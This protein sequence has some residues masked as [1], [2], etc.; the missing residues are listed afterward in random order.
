VAKGS[1]DVVVGDAYSG[2]SV[3]WHLTTL[4]YNRQIEAVLTGDGLYIM[5]V[6]D[7]GEL[8]FLRAETATLIEV[9]DEVAL[10]APPEYLTGESGG[11]FILVSSRDPVDLAAVESRIRGRG[12]T[13]IGISGERLD[14]FVSGA[15]VLTDDYAPVDQMLGR[16]GL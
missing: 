9:Y 11:N 16:A 3:P 12:G 6:I 1:A 7:Y 10:F 5:N 2:A 8:A 13:E 15:P 4:E 14:R